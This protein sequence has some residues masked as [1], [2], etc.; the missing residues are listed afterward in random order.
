[1]SHQ[2][3]CLRYLGLAFLLGTMAAVDARPQQSSTLNFEVNRGQTAEQVKFLT[4]RPDYS[5][6][7][8]PTQ[9]TLAL[10]KTSSQTQVV[11]LSLFGA[12]AQASMTGAEPLPGIVNYF[13]GSDP[14]KWQTKIATYQQVVAQGIYPGIDIAYYGKARSLEYDFRVAPGADPTQIRMKLGGVDTLKLNRNGDLVLHTALGMI[15]QH[16]PVSYQTIKGQKKYIASRYVLEG[17]EV[18]LA[19]GNYD[20]SQPLVIDPTLVYST[21]LGGSSGEV[22]NKLVADNAGAVY[23]VGTTTSTDFP[24]TLGTVSNTAQ[25]M[26]NIF[27]TK[28]ATTGSLLTYSTYLGG[29]GQDFGKSIAVDSMGNVYITGDTRSAD[30]PTYPP[31]G[32]F[33][34]SY[35]GGLYGGDA[36]VVKIDTSGSVLKYAT[37]LGGNRSDSGNAIAVDSGGNAF[38]TG[39]TDSPDFPTTSGSYSTTLNNAHDVFVTKLNAS[40]SA[41][42]YSS[43]LGS[44]AEDFARAIAIDSAGNAYVAGFTTI[45]FGTASDFPATAGTFETIGGPVDIFLSKFNPTGSGLIYSSFLGGTS[46]EE[47]KALALDSAG[48]AYLTGFTKSRDFPKTRAAFQTVFNAFDDGFVTEF[49]ASGLNLVYSTFLGGRSTDYGSDIAVDTYGNTYVTGYTQSTAFPTTPR[50]FSVDYGGGNYDAFVVKLSPF[51]QTLLYG[52]LLGGTSTD[53]SYGLS[54]DR[55]GTAYIAGETESFD[56]PITVGAFGTTFNASLLSDAFVTRLGFV[57]TLTGFTPTSGKAGTPVVINGTNFAGTTQVRFNN[58][59]ASFKLASDGQLTATAPIGV[60]TGTIT[61][62]NPGGNATSTSAFTVTP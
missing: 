6:F 4:H 26:S 37:F 53:I 17:N 45:N 59:V 13:Y 47:A 43:Y 41:L 5:L 51:A 57:P 19:L 14:K 54:L 16:R 33:D 25:G 28:V 31:I 10:R 1:M 21:F 24:T 44:S 30:F 9:A 35:N 60:T 20:R 23:V 40:G 2:H 36:F 7:L 49:D 22:I 52:T 55:L 58:K 56:L 3:F 42:T 48:N 15:E 11:Q 62:N 46:Y 38:I 8:T 34:T 32:A 61:V 50:A 27:V 18:R 29:S 39:E 12:N